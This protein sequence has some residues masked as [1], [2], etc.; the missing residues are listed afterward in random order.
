MNRLHIAFLMLALS[1][2]LVAMD[3]REAEVATVNGEAISLRSLE[4]ELLRKEGAEA[5]QRL[6][7]DQ[8]AATQWSEVEDDDTLI[9]MPGWRLPRLPVAV[10]LLKEKGGE[11]REELINLILVKQAL[12]RAELE[13]DEALLQAERA[14]MEQRFY[15]RLRQENQPWVSFEN[16]IKEV[17]GMPVEEWIQQPGFRVLAGVHALLYRSFELPEEELRSYYQANKRQYS[18]PEA[19]DVWVLFLPF[20][21][22]P[23]Q[24]VT[25]TNRRATIE[26]AQNFHEALRS[27]RMTWEK[28][29]RLLGGRDPGMGHKGWVDRQGQ[30]LKLGEADVPRA[31]IEQAFAKRPRGDESVLLEP[32]VHDS[33][34]SI[35][36]VA[37]YRSGTT[38]SFEQV[39]EQV[40]RDAIDA[41]LETYSARFLDRLRRQASV[42]YASMPGLIDARE[43][44][45]VSLMRAQQA[46]AVE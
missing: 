44:A 1:I 32:I 30:A 5:V 3:A 43:Q 33:G 17:E 37:D 13:I 35:L 19:V 27:G 20:R 46:E 29:Y 39:R 8:I 2:R 7:A 24:Q 25:P 41:N 14:T 23:D 40:H 34:V 18:Q 4:D 31:V 42:D 38:P 6:V 12:A 10:S 9:A 16:Y 28:V 11:V 15:D 26:L 22:S 45:A 36:K 21:T